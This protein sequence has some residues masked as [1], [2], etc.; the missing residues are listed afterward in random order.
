[1]NSTSPFQNIMLLCLYYS[2]LKSDV[3][4][5]FCLIGSAGEQPVWRL[6]AGA[7]FSAIA[8]DMHAVFDYVG[9]CRER[10]GPSVGHGKNRR[11]NKGWIFLPPQP[12]E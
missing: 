10:G 1:M 4:I 11:M 5:N 3:N 2:I 7:P 9:G 8:L 6:P 12:R